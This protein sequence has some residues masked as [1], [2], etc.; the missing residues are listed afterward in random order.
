MPE[1][2]A[3]FLH[4]ELGLP[5]QLGVGE[6]RV[7]GEIEDVTLSSRGDLVGKITADNLAESL[8]DLEDGAASARAQVPGLDTGLLLAEV[9]QSDKMASGKVDD[10]DVVSNGGAV[11]GFVV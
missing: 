10:V 7:G 5:L 9:V 8:D 11:S 3:G 1:V 4:G 2:V 6:G